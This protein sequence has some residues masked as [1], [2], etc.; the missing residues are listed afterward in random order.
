MTVNASETENLRGRQRITISWTGAQPSGGRASNP[1]GEKGLQQEY[2]VVILQ[3][4]GRDD[5]VAPG[6]EAAA[7]RDLLDR[8]GRPAVADHP[9][10]RARRPGPTTSTRDAGRQGAGLRHDPVPDRGG[11]PD[12]RPGPVLHPADAVRRREGQASTRPATARP[13]AARGG[14]RTRPSRPPRSRPSPT[15]TAPARSQ[16]EVRSDVENESLGCNHKVACSI[17]VIPINGLSCDRP[18]EP[19]DDRPTRPAARAAGSRPGSSNFS[20]RGRRP[21]GLARRCGG[22]RPTGRTGSRSRSPSACRRTPATSSTRGRRPA[23]TAPSCWPRRRCS[24]PRRTAWTRSASSSSTTRC[25]TRP[26]WNLME[27][28][29]GAGRRRLLRARAARRRPG[30]LRA[31]RGDRLLDRLRHRPAR[32]RRASTPSSGST[33]G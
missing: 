11:V 3:C 19:G 33:R 15:P 23:S 24:G 29:G 4:R 21:G 28:G 8:V 13:H 20:Q 14:R 26:G 18:S 32:Q 17:V 2:P 5:A 27:S 7:S 6:G 1:Y 12:R 31:D 25:P 10:R 16:F 22:R 9:V 30:G